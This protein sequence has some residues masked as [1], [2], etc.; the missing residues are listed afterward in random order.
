MDHLNT[1]FN[2]KIVKIGA[3]CVVKQGRLH[4]KNDG[5]SSV[6]PLFMSKLRVDRLVKLNNLPTVVSLKLHF[7]S[8]L[9]EVKNLYS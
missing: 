9:L 6:V 7:H 4:T 1:H 3:G 5:V 8:G 2:L